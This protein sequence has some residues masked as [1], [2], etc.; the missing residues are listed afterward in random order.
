M[1]QSNASKLSL[2]GPSSSTTESNKKGSASAPDLNTST[3]GNGGFYATS[4]FPGLCVTSEEINFLVY[5]YLQESGKDENNRSNN[6]LRVT[7]YFKANY[8]QS[9]AA[10]LN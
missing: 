10:D 7:L 1:S 6:S 3:N 4:S 5:R 8:L 2:A 9:Y